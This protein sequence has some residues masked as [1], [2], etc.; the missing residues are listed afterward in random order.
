MSV[1]CPTCGEKYEKL[2]NHF[3][4]NPQHRPELSERQRAIIEFLILRGVTIRGEGQNFRLEG[5]GTS[6]AWIHEVT[7]A[8]GWVANDPY[9]HQSASDVADS[10]ERRYRNNVSVSDCS[11]VWGFTSVSHPSLDYEGPTD[12]EQLRPLTLRLLIGAV[13]T[14]VGML[15]GS[16]HVD[17]RGW[18]VSGDHMSDLLN[19]VGVETV[20]YDGDG[21]AT[22]THT[23]R[24]HYDDDVVVAPHY[25][26]I[27]LLDSV[28][29]SISDVAEPIKLQ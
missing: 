11:D 26:A 6:E 29:L 22:D 1:K 7:D 14:W 27:E 25:D 17:V 5:Y 3:A 9:L 18:D 10:V 19:N 28:G 2:G 12:V 20:E 13:G 4:W 8:L 16:L 21:Y 24:Y 23:K 15:F